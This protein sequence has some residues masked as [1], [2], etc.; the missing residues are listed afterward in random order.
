M[1]NNCYLHY[2]LHNSQ[3]VLM[4]LVFYYKDMIEKGT[5]QRSQQFSPFSLLAREP[6]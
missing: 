6:S 5:M 1:L 2:F 4:V 3:N